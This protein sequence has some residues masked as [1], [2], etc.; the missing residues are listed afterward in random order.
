MIYIMFEP[1]ALGDAICSVG[2]SKFF[3]EKEGA[4]VFVPVNSNLYNS[5]CSFYESFPNIHVREVGTEW[6]V[7]KDSLYSIDIVNPYDW[8]YRVE[9]VREWVVPMWD[10]Q[11]YTICE[12]PFS[13]RYTSF[14][15]STDRSKELK[16]S[17]VG[18]K[19]YILTHTSY[20]GK[21]GISIDLSSWR[22]SPCD[23]KVIELSP[24]ITDNVS[25]YYDLIIGSSEIHCVPSSMYCLVDTI[26]NKVSGELFLHD[27]RIDTSI[28]FNNKWNKGCW[29]WVH[30][31]EK[32]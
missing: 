26:W 12:V 9:G 8:N 17:L 29:G 23:T 5:V 16:D 30:Y 13:Y 28:H 14:L 11:M 18:D 6:Y 3:S 25:D 31:S 15:K 22:E 4:T 19:P 27:I 7:F 1:A 24:N 10:Q 21:N 2:I 32:E 20:Q